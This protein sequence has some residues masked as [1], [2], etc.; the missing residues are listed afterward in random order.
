MY[1]FRSAHQHHHPRWQTVTSLEVNKMNIEELEKYCSEFLIHA[2]DVEG[3]QKGIDEVGVRVRV[4]SPLG[5]VY[6]YHQGL[7]TLLL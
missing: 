4:G 5:T 1:F 2:A 3:L 6:L 7:P